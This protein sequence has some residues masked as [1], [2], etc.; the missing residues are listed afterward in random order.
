M[1]EEVFGAGDTRVALLAIIGAKLPMTKNT[2]RLNSGNIPR[3]KTIRSE[4][5]V[6]APNEDH[7]T[8]VTNHLL[9]LIMT[10]EASNSRVHKNKHK[11]NVETAV[12]R[13][14]DEVAEVPSAHTLY[15]NGLIREKAV[16]ILSIVRNTSRDKDI[17][18]SSKACISK[19]GTTLV[20]KAANAVE[21]PDTALFVISL[22]NTI[23]HI[24]HRKTFD[25]ML[26]HDAAAKRNFDGPKGCAHHKLN[27]S[28]GVNSKTAEGALVD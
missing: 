18:H 11:N 14:A 28:T 24:R 12:M 25:G 27:H 6:L 20:G 15:D 17:D 2:I 8:F 21:G 26:C 4:H 16:D 1:L 13:E 22:K 19:G 7:M 9:S 10:A 23:V 5:D 3:C